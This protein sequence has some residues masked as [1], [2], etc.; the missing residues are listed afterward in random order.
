MLLTWVKARELASTAQSSI[1]RVAKETRSGQTAKKALV[2]VP[3][4]GSFWFWYRNQPVSYRTGLV[5]LGFHKEEQ[6][7]LTCL[8]RSSRLLRTLMDECELEYSAQGEKKTAIFEHHEDRW[9][10]IASRNV[11]PLSTVILSEK[12][13]KTLVDHVKEFLEPQAKNW[14][15]Q[16]SLAYRQGYLL[17]G[18]PGTGKSSLSLS[19][20]GEFDLDMYIVSIPSVTDQLLQKL[21]LSLPDRCMVLLED[22]DAVGMSRSD[23][24]PDSS[25]PPKSVI[26]KRSPNGKQNLTLSGLLNTLDGVGSAEGRIVMMTTNHID[27]LDGALIRPGRVDLKVEIGLADKDVIGQIFCYMYK[28]EKG[29]ADAG[30]SPDIQDQAAQFAAIVPQGTFSQ[31]EILSYL[32]QHR[33]Q[34]AEALRNCQKWVDD[35]RQEKS[36]LRRGDSWNH[37][38]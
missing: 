3:W 9:I 16:K 32:L 8:G 7:S 5:D 33:V 1:V 29:G 2:Y 12:T 21:F 11:R 18:P 19:V 17:Y 6:V 34:P 4:N 26:P 22:I 24:E 27:R 28:Q 20:A 38:G 13:K 15:S 31:A 30:D 14:Y 35:M 23:S 25:G 37:C 10:R 36:T